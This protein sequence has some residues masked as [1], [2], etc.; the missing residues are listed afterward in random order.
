MTT[1]QIQVPFSEEII[2]GVQFG[3]LHPA[4]VNPISRHC[5]LGENNPTFPARSYH[6]TTPET[7]P[8][9]SPI[10]GVVIAANYQEN[11]PTSNNIL[12]HKLN[13]LHIKTKEGGVIKIQ[14]IHPT[15]EVGQHVNPKEPVGEVFGYLAE[16]PT[17]DAHIHLKIES[18]NDLMQIMDLPKDWQDFRRELTQHCVDIYQDSSF[19]KREN[20]ANIFRNPS[21]RNNIKE[22][23]LA[24]VEK[25]I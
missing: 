18:P 2:R 6:I 1:Y 24:E 16:Y 12:V 21:R 7:C 22:V 25:R 13:Y 11:F 9:L 4:M 14:H 5:G 15:V 3:F 17:I 19:S 8:I 10:K 20:E 23:V